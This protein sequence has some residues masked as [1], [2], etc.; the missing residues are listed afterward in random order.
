MFAMSAAVRGLDA[1]NRSDVRAGVT[2]DIGGIPILL[3]SS[4]ADFRSMIEQ[5]Y[6][7]FVN[8]AALPAYTFDI[9]LRSASHGSD[10]DAIAF[11]RGSTWFV[12]RGDFQAEWDVRSRHGVVRQSANPYSLDT[13]LRITH[14]LALAAEG[15]FLLHAA[16]A[17]RNGLAFVFAGVSGAGKTT[18]S[19]LA[20]PDATVLT[21]EISYFRRD[22][23]GYR[24]YGTPFAGE[25]ARIGANV[26]APIETVFLLEKGPENR[27]EAV[28]EIT[29]ARAL[30]RHLLFFA[31][32]GELVTH[33]FD[34][35]L[36]FVRHVHV[37]KLIFTPD[38]RAWELVR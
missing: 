36:N 35:V 28:S 17:V 27:I 11:T 24:A 7:S 16:S 14:S 3:R 18:M 20:P 12:Q 23:H 13:V 34:S 10:D 15:G 4:D 22:E 37:A 8:P 29:A 9:D 25:L 19:R 1:N 21:D 6:S 31:N 32:D 26:S 5:R 38:A 2:V 30:L 33:V